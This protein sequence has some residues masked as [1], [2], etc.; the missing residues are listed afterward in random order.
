MGELLSIL[1]DAEQLSTTISSAGNAFVWKTLVPTKPSP[2]SFL[3][4]V[5]HLT[6]KK[7]LGQ[8]GERQQE[9]AVALSP[10]RWT[11]GNY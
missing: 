9:P 11:D 8:N 7:Q 3:E 6:A 4:R 5:M 1:L 10:L 2:S